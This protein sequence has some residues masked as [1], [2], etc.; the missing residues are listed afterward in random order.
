MTEQVASYDADER[1]CSVCGLPARRLPFCAG[2][3]IR[4]ETV[5][6]ALPGKDTGAI[7]KHGYMNLDLAFEAIENVQRE[8][9][10]RGRE[11]P[12]L[13]AEAKRQVA[14][15]EVTESRIAK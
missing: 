4:G 8:S 15:G 5:A 14:S 13:F 2:V 3:A 9:R 10:K 7:T 6:K 11:P 12:D 1:P